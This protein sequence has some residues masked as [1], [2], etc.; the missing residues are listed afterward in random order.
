M[1]KLIDL[2][3]AISAIPD[4]ALIGLGGNALNRAPIAAVFEIVRQKKTCLEIV[5]TAGAMDIDILCLAGC[6]K[7]VSAGF[8]SYE[9]EFSLAQH[10]RRSVQKGLVKANEHACYTVISA[11]RAAA[12]GVPFM[13]VYGL[14]ASD[15]IDANPYFRRITDPFSGDPVTIVS[16]ISPDYAIV[17][18]HKA[19]KLG[20]A[21]IFGPK[22]EDVLLSR[23]SKN[24][25]LTTEEVV[26]T[27]YFQSSEYKAD[28][29]DFLVSGVVHVPG[30]AAPCACHGLYEADA[31]GIQ[32]FLN[33]K[34]ESGLPAYLA[35]IK[36]ASRV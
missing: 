23:A 3:T 34:D 19:D 35:Q 16:A 5:K 18:V 28:I 30:G 32:S 33:I 29:P 22:Y 24:V 4:N 7:S 25:I 17:H 20:N 15:L 14:M 9:T 31:S 10:Y 21:V 26:G 8:V 12:Y 11:L 1:D 13:P 36:E 27:D 2:Q 6:V